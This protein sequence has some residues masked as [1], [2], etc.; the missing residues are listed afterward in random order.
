MYSQYIS[1]KGTLI[2][3][4]LLSGIGRIVAKQPLDSLSAKAQSIQAD[5]LIIIGQHA[6]AQAIYK[7]IAPVFLEEKAWDDHIHCLTE[8]GHSYLGMS[9]YP[10]A[11]IYFDSALHQATRFLTP[12]APRYYQIYNKYGQYYFEIG[13]FDQAVDYFERAMEILVENDIAKGSH[14][15]AMYNNLGT[16]YFNLGFQSKALSYQLTALQIKLQDSIPN[17]NLTSSYMGIGIN[18]M[19]TGDYDNAFS[20]LNQALDISIAQYGPD[21]SYTAMCYVHIGRVYYRLKDYEKAIY[22]DEKAQD[23]W[24]THYGRKYRYTSVA[25]NDLGNCYGRLKDFPRQL[26]QYQSSLAI[27]LD[28]L[29]PIHPQTGVSYMNI[30]RCYEQLGKEKLEKAAYQKALGI[31]EQIYSEQ[32]PFM[33]L[34]NIRLG[35]LASRQA[36]HT[37]ALQ[38]FQQAANSL[39]LDT[40]Y[41]PDSLLPPITSV[42]VLPHFLT[43]LKTRA[44]ALSRQNPGTIAALKAHRHTVAFI[45]SMILSYRGKGALKALADEAFA[46]YEGAIQAA[47]ALYHTTYQHAYLEEAFKYVEKSK[48]LLLH[49]NLRSTSALTYG[50]IPPEMLEKEQTLR[51]SLNYHEEKLLANALKP[52]PDPLAQQALRKT[53]HTLN[54]DYRQFISQLETNYP[55]YYRLKYDLEVPDVATIQLAL[56]GKTSHFLEYFWGTDSL[57]LFEI[58]LQ[59]L[60]YHS[61]GSHEDLEPKLSLFLQALKSPNRL[62]DEKEFS[63]YFSTFCQTGKELGDVLLPPHIRKDIDNQRLLIVPDGPLGYLPF[64]SL[65][66]AY[67]GEEKHFGQVDYVLHHAAIG[68]AYSAISHTSDPPAQSGKLAAFAPEYS[69]TNDVNYLPAL[70]KNQEEAQHI[71]NLWNGDVFLGKTALEQVFKEK[72]HTYGMLHL[73]MHAFANDQNPMYS[74]M[75]FTDGQLSALHAKTVS[76][77]PLSSPLPSRQMRIGSLADSLVRQYLSTPDTLSDDNVLHAFE[78]YGLSLEASLAVLSA[79]QTGEGKMSR[80]EGIMSLARAFRFAGCPSILTSL[81]AADD[82]ATHEVMVNFYENLKEGIPKDLAL[83][84]AKLSH[85]SQASPIQA[86]PYFWSGFVLIGDCRP[87]QST[88]PPTLLYIVVL[89]ALGLIIGGIWYE[90]KSTNK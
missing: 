56:K 37:R 38:L 24:L 70:Q 46:A 60:T 19:E 13:E 78:V 80:G 12:L 16:S 10:Q 86:Y 43:C 87:L 83:Q 45:D 67:T 54:L 32:H 21:H 30:G 66:W 88:S 33:A 44:T 11:K 63:T 14:L 57:Y 84:Q 50:G 69:P 8:I 25:I 90:I 62:L 61:L 53:L 75:V 72:A 4:L 5:T 51:N 42:R 47:L 76:S 17:P 18:Y 68:Y 71:S 65:V 74:G 20:Y 40:T 1:F 55:T 64:E 34:A 27:T 39:L 89:L 82:H 58:S 85:L 52:N 26:A 35:D 9:Q 29:G 73:A 2:A 22:Y 31:F 7:Q 77:P 23:I 59:G 48:A 28:I 3:L 81:W 41:S 6:K 49:R 36:A 79:C 15:A